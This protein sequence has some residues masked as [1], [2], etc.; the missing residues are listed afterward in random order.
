MNVKCSAGVISILCALNMSRQ[1]LAPELIQ[2]CLAEGLHSKETP[3]PSQ[4]AVEGNMCLFWK[5]LKEA[6]REPDPP[7]SLVLFAPKS[8]FSPR[9]PTSLLLI[10]CPHLLQPPGSHISFFIP[11]APPAHSSPLPW[12]HLW[13]CPELVLSHARHIVKVSV[14]QTCPALC[15]PM[16]CS[17]PGSSVLW[18]QKEKGVTE[19]EMVS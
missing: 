8:Q 14:T 4:K 16:D 17:P 11:K 19:N 15:D 12:N 10:G 9:D 13:G 18:R 6:E 3:I 5:C 7:A 1:L 2:A